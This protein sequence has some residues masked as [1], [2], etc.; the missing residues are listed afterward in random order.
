LFTDLVKLY[1]ASTTVT[2]RSEV[3]NYPTLKLLYV[4]EQ[5][6][7]AES[8]VDCQYLNKLYLEIDSF[9]RVVNLSNV[10]VH[11]NEVYYYVKVITRSPRK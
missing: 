3:G 4:C 9:A 7:V 6:S 11:E 2:H 8:P 10:K 1:L 5:V